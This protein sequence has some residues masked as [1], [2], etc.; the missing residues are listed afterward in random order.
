MF[1][2]LRTIILGTFKGVRA[3]TTLDVM[4]AA[5]ELKLDIIELQEELEFMMNTHRQNQALIEQA[6]I[7]GYINVDGVLFK[8]A[9][10]RTLPTITVN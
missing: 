8:V 7:D 1:K 10:E 2:L 3:E 9:D 5:E 4:F 6:K